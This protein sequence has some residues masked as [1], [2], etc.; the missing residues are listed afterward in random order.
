VPLGA[1]PPGTTQL[2]IS[3]NQEVYWDRIAVAWA[4][5][6]PQVRK[7]VLEPIVADMRRTGFAKRT[8]GDQR[9]PYYD[10]DH[11]PPYWDTRHQSGYYTAFGDARELV[12][13]PDDAVAIFGPGE[14]V[15]LEFDAGLDPV[16]PG[17]TRRFVLE[18]RGWCKDMD[19]Y[20]G[21]AETV[22]PLPGRRDA[23]G[24][25]L[26]ERYNTRYESGKN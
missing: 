25:R 5:P 16:P 12:A 4:E 24:E 23:H 20:T 7:R 1:V 3:T 9:Q 19:L 10:Y 15:H 11:R 22:G 21:D 8:T 2:R 17:W 6:A 26:H 14:E 13:E 18:T